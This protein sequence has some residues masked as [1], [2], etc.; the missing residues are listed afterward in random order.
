MAGDDT[1]PQT[2][3]AYDVELY[4]LSDVLVIRTVKWQTQHGECVETRISED[5]G[6]SW[7]PTSAPLTLDGALMLDRIGA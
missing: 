7:R 2:H 6:R 3:Y 5:Y 4:Q 1:D